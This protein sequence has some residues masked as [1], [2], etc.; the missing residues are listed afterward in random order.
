MIPRRAYTGAA[1]G[2]HAKLCGQGP[3]AEAAAACRLPRARA[4]A[5]AICNLH[6]A[7]QVLFGRGRFSA[8]PKPGRTSFSVKLARAGGCNE[9]SVS[10]CAIRQPRH[11]E[12]CEPVV[13]KMNVH[14][15]GRSCK[16]KEILLHNLCRVI[17]HR[18]DLA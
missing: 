13:L 18:V 2:P 15:R 14:V 5:N 8:G 1:N 3:R 12:G 16:K 6:D 9:F 4:D 10:N 11:A 7:E 17:N